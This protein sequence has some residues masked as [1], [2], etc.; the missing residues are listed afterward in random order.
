VAQTVE[1]VYAVGRAEAA[2]CLATV[3]E[4]LDMGFVEDES[5][6]L[7]VGAVGTANL[8]TLIP[9]QASPS[10]VSEQTVFRAG[11]CPFLVSV[12]SRSC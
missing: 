2:I 9:L 5:L 12:S 11:D 3:E 8:G 6:G 4:G 10:Q 1:G 7:A